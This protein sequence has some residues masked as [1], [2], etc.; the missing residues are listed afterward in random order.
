M[1]CALYRSPALL[2]K[3]AVTI[4]HISNGRANLGVGAG[5]FKEEFEEYGY[6][7][8]PIGERFEHLEEA[9]QVIRAMFE[10]PS[11]TF[12]GRYY[13]VT[14]AVCSPKPVQMRLPIW[15]GGRGP[16]RTPATAAR[17]ADGFN[18]PYISADEYKKRLA[19]VD[20]TCERIGRDPRTIRRTVNLGFYMGADAKS[21]EKNR[22]RTKRHTPEQQGGL[23]AGQAQ[24][25]IDKIE[26]YVKAGAQGVNIAIRPPVDWDALD[27]FIERV[28][29][30][31]HK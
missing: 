21:A 14:N 26:T 7:F 1:F 5:W 27:A 6:R 11:V 12:K 22:E 20:E 3:A 28:M 15:V 17:L 16:E 2:A 8:P 4:D 31:F 18:V 30:H 13:Q 23:L 10:Q 29:P 19:I 9:L 25:V 24:E